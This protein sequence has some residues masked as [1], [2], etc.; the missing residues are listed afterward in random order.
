MPRT[1]PKFR[2]TIEPPSPPLL[3]ST[4]LRSVEELVTAP[5]DTS[6]S[7]HQDDSFL[8]FAVAAEQQGS[9][10]LVG[11][12]RCLVVLGNSTSKFSDANVSGCWRCFPA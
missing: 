6:L 3:Q 9:T 5:L 8:N 12:T 4:P 11:P 2:A 1:L 10:G 7:V